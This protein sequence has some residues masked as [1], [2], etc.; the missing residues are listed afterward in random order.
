MWEWKFLNPGMSGNAGFQSGN[1][2]EWKYLIR[3]YPGMEVFDP[4]M[5]RNEGFDPGIS[6]NVFF[7]P[8]MVRNEFLY[9]GISENR[10][11]R[12]RNGQEWVFFIR[13]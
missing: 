12:S 8:V 5:T 2:R 7:N 6:G 1:I 9:P 13:E 3:E 11:F 10:G 4:G